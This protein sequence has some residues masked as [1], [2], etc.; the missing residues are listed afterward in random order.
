MPTPLPS[1]F[2][3]AAAGN[4]DASRRGDGTAS[5]EWARNRMNG[6]TQTFRRPSVATNP[7]HSRDTSQPASATTPTAGTY[8]PPHMLSN[9]QSS[10]LRNG[11]TNDTRYS[12]EQL[13][14]LYKAQRETGILG[15]NLAEYLAADWNPQVETSAANGA[16]G[17]REDSKDNP[18]GPGVCW[19]HGGQM[20][21]LS[22]V[23]MTDDEKEVRVFCYL[24]CLRMGRRALVW[25]EAVLNGRSCFPSQ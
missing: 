5:G 6:A 24:S 1:S 21:P 4:T 25:E 10:A 11:A 13:L 20:E 17:R 15:K 3:S 16:W 19:D 2:A 8:T 22:L 12:K 14:E 23:D 9:Y 18:S 7:S